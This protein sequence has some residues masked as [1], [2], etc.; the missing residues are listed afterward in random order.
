MDRMRHLQSFRNLK[1]WKEC[2]SLTLVIY[3]STRTF[4]PDERFGLI[5]QL[6]KAAVSLESNIAEGSGRGTDSDFRRFL[7]IA[8]G[9]L[10][11]VE[12]QVLVSKDLG[13]LNGAA[14]DKLIVQIVEIR[15]MLMSL[16]GRLTASSQTRR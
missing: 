5:Q 13:W 11:E 12:C 8:L 10:A 7:F 16:I 3:R 15:R 6:R 2:H 9:S 14:Y 4:P 1:V